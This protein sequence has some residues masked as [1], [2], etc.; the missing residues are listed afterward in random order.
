MIV[1]PMIEVISETASVN[2]MPAASNFHLV[3]SA[4]SCQPA[5]TPMKEREMQVEIQYCGM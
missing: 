2:S 5:H 1:C 3:Y 4:V